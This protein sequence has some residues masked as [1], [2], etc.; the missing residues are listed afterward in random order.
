MATNRAF[1]LDE[2]LH[3]RITLA[4]EFLVPDFALRQEIWRQ[5]LLTDLKLDKD[6]DLKELAMNYELTGGF[7]KN[8][9]IYQKKKTSFLNIFLI[10]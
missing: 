3:R 10:D 6:V 4:I 2:A 1:D 9:I 7:I 5:H 8:V